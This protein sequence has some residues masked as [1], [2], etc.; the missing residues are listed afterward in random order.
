MNVMLNNLGCITGIVIRMLHSYA[1]INFNKVSFT[2]IPLKSIPKSNQ[3]NPN[4]FGFD[5]ESSITSSY[6]MGG[7]TVEWSVARAMH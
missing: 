6:D 7:P 4:Q 3:L 2:Q 1:E 5:S